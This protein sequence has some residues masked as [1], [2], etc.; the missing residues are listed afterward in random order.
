MTNNVIYQS[1]GLHLGGLF[2]LTFVLF[3]ALNNRQEKTITT[4]YFYFLITSTYLVNIFQ[5]AAFV[6]KYLEEYEN[7]AIGGTLAMV[8]AR[9]FALASI[10]FGIAAECYFVNKLYSTSKRKVNNKKLLLISC[11]IGM[12]FFIVSC[13]FKV[14]FH[15]NSEKYVLNGPFSYGTYAA[16]AATIIVVVVCYIKNFKTANHI[17]RTILPYLVGSYAFL[18][19]LEK[20]VGYDISEVPYIL[21]F[22][23]MAIYFSIENNNILK[24]EKYKEE[25]ENARKLEAKLSNQYNESSTKVLTGLNNMYIITKIMDNKQ[26]NDQEYNDKINELLKNGKNA[27]EALTETGDD[28]K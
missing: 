8:F 6:C 26:L 13:L 2:F 23:T 17:Q 16:F 15:T 11:I 25:Q 7:L 4:K 19:M 5:I 12:I 9:L 10:T 24:L 3:I 28:S 21:S 14:N 27:M 22:Y 20:L 18:V 1:I